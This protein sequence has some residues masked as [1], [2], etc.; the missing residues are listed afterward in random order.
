MD[1]LLMMISSHWLWVNWKKPL[2]IIKGSKPESLIKH[3]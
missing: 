1:L 3:I 2:A